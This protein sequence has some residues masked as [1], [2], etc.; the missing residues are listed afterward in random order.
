MAIRRS[1]RSAVGL[2]FLV[3][4]S[5]SPRG[6]FAAETGVAVRATAD[7][8]LRGAAMW[9]PDPCRPTADAVQLRG[10]L[11][12]C[13]QITV[14]A[15]PAGMPTIDSVVLDLPDG[16]GTGLTGREYQVRG[17]AHLTPTAARTTPWRIPLSAVFDFLTAAPAACRR[18]TVMV[19]GDLL[20]DP[21]GRLN[22]APC[23]E[24]R[25]CTHV[26][27]HPYRLDEEPLG[28]VRPE[29]TRP[30]LGEPETK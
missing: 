2:A 30:A 23:T 8:A 14:A 3:L 18:G 11:R 7:L 25:A 29:G 9:F 5:L 27:V 10:T 28:Y 1:G 12:V 17:T 13:T 4:V 20:F 19:R 15:D 24:T 22:L 21:N 16:R 6:A 26:G